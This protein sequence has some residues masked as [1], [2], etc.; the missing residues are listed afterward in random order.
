MRI[1]SIDTF[2]CNAYRTNWVF[3]RIRTDDGIH[4]WAKPLSFRDARFVFLVSI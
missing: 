1:D 2:V 4:G 3:V